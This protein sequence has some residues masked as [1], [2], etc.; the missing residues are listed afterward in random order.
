MN[1]SNKNELVCH[2]CGVKLDDGTV[3]TG[4]HRNIPESS[5]RSFGVMREF[6]TTS[7]IPIEFAGNK[8]H[9]F[10][11]SS[12]HPV[13]SEH[14]GLFNSFP[15]FSQTFTVKNESHKNSHG[16]ISNF[17]EG[18]VL[19][20]MKNDAASKK[21][22]IFA[23]FQKAYKESDVISSENFIAF[24]KKNFSFTEKESDK[25]LSNFKLHSPNIKTSST[26]SDSNSYHLS[27]VFDFLRHK[28]L[29]TNYNDGKIDFFPNSDV[30]SAGI[31]SLLIK[32]E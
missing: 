14:N 5:G 21:T 26:A 4:C 2:F 9:F 31:Q 19:D 10:G 16:E 17:E 8:R 1:E 24:L 7:Q 22:T 11:H 29:H 25:F 32:V 20:K 12:K 15:Q 23:I 3:N 13:N 6:Y 27:D 30:I 18:N 28:Q